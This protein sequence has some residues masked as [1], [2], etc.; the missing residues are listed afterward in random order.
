MRK[1]FI[2]GLT[3]GLVWLTTACA[4][5]GVSIIK[6]LPGP[7]TQYQSVAVSVVGPQA[8]A[9]QKTMVKNLLMASLGSTR[10]FQNIYDYDNGNDSE[11]TQLLLRVFITKIAEIDRSTLNMSHALEAPPSSIT[12]DVSFVDAKTSATTGEI[13]AYGESIR[14]S[15]GQS[16]IEVAASAAI[17]HVV[18]FINQNQ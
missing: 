2:A 17:Q 7:L 13:S 16:E 9:E 4:P 8:S 12:M 18:D 14:K 6:N 10:K 5:G 15:Q 11:K 3:I 1:G